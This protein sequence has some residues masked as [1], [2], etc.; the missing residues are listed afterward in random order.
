MIE[1]SIIPNPVLG[2]LQKEECSI[3]EVT[4]VTHGEQNVYRYVTP[5]EVPL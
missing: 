2:R 5:T 3:S 1:I 4:I